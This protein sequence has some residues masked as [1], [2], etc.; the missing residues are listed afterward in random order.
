MTVQG[1]GQ[2]EFVVQDGHEYANAHGD[3]HRGLHRVK[4][5]NLPLGSRPIL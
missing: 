3:P 1:A 2:L 4:H 5:F